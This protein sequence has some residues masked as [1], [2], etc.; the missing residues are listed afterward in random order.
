VS[1][2]RNITSGL[3][4]LFRREQVDQELDEELRAYQEMAAQEK[5]NQGGC[6]RHSVTSFHRRYSIAREHFHYRRRSC[7]NSRLRTSQGQF[8]ESDVR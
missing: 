7:K 5:M 1:L 6:I 8:R 3:R 2:L 4:S